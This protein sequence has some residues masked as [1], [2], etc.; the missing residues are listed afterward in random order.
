MMS[1]SHLKVIFQTDETVHKTHPEE[2]NNGP[3]VLLAIGTFGDENLNQAHTKRSRENPSSSL[4]QHL[5]D[6]TPEELRKLQKEFNILL[7]EHLK[8]SSPSLELEVRKHCQSNIFLSRQSSFEFETTKNKPYH[9][10]LNEKSDSFQHVILSKGKDVG[11]EDFD[12]TVIGKRT[13]SLLLKKIFIC[14]GGSA[15]AAVA[16][17]LR[18]P[19]LESKMEK[20]KPGTCINAPP[21]TLCLLFW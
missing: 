2:F 4:Q 10:E 14:G 20:V 17:P 6:L 7:D 3:H 15:H 13:L 19:N 11:V 5:Q 12:T 8:Q 16:P 9:D 21:C 1:A 18:I